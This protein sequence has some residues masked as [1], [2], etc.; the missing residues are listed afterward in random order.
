VVH[1]EEVCVRNILSNGP[2]AVLFLLGACGPKQ[3]DTGN[4]GQ[5][6]ASA[7]PQIAS[8]TDPSTGIDNSGRLLPLLPASGTS[9]AG[10]S[11]SSPGSGAAREMESSAAELTSLLSLKGRGGFSPSVIIG[12]DDRAKV[13]STTTF[14]ERAQV[15]IELSDGRC[16]GAMIAKDL[17]LTAGHCVH[18]GGQ[19]A[20]SVTVYPGKDGAASP[21]GSCR[22]KTLYSVVGWTRDADPNYD[23]GAIKLDCPIGARTGWLGYYWQPTTLAGTAARI[24][25]YPG[26]KPLEQWSHTDQVRRDSPLKTY[27]FTDTKG[28]NSGSSVFT[29][30]GPAGCNG[31][32]VH[33]VHAYGE[34]ANQRNSGTRITKALFDN[35]QRWSAEP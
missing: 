33:T 32:C 30:Q 17:V 9:A 24:S 31:P 12:D 21:Y 35:L 16:S 7:S 11:A 18:S 23:F 8:N 25:S 34:Q 28:G 10:V 29:S 5:P 4:Q 20:T 1:R 27:Y 19:W 2:I 3:G 26:D 6:E 15:L 13:A 14:P 22:A